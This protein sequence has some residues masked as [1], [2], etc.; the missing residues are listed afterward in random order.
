M[1]HQ[2]H[3]GGKCPEGQVGGKDLEVMGMEDLG[4]PVKVNKQKE[5]EEQRSRKGLLGIRESGERKPW[6]SWGR[7]D[8]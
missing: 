7:G 3:P 2:G 8:W 5:P 4:H 6:R 1:V